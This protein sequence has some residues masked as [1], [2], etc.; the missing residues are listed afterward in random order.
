MFMRV[1]IWLHRYL[2]IALGWL[3]VV[4][5]LSGIVMMY[6]PFPR[7]DAEA[8]ERGLAPLEWGG[9]A[10]LADKLSPEQKY[11]RFQ[12]EMMAG[13]PVL[14]LWPHEAP[15][16]LLQLNAPRD[17]AGV[18][19]IQAR[20]VA[21]RYARVPEDRAA[22]PIVERI[23]YDQW[24]VGGSRSD[25]PLY[26]VVV[27]DG[28]GT[29]VYVSSHSGVVVQATTRAQRFW[30]WLGAVPHWLYLSSLRSR[31]V[32][33]TQVVIWTSLLG[34]FLTAIGLVI[35]VRALLLSAGRGRYSPFRGAALWH[36]LVGL[37]FGVLALTW[38]LSG[39]FSMNPWGLM[40][41][42]DPEDAQ[43][44][45][46]GKATDGAAIAALLRNLSARAP[47][48]V[49]GIDSAPLDGALYVVGI[50]GDGTRT[51]YDFQGVPR[52]LTN[53]EISAAVVRLI[54]AGTS[55]DLLRAQDA[56]HYG[57]AS[58]RVP[59]PVIRSVSATG[60][61]YYLDPVSGELVDR[62]DSGER[63]YRWWFSALHRWD[64]ARGLRTNPGR[65]LV[66]LPL[67]LGTTLLTALGAYLGI[68]RL[69]RSG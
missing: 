36:H 6:E 48:G 19:E 58:E 63:H 52:P 42:A 25:R 40:E 61:F 8:R 13:S 41:G 5:C 56:Y 54:G 47:S 30:G 11:S 45:L 39:L 50:R 12:L 46:A 16:Q 21:A 18:A 22:A 49:V 24:T 32:A 38:V 4:W 9:V 44:R 15:M 14:R 55:W 37:V 1:L 67:L 20:D 34:V 43:L 31:P 28:D 69:T 66:M 65:T 2:G 60:D 29:E 51:R 26:R 68:R 62:A 27:G 59:L 10:R 23:A 64:F 17:A 57:V 3:L 33:W 53:E 35:G 7:V